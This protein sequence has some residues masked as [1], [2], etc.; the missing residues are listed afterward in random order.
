LGRSRIALLDIDFH[1]NL[2]MNSEDQPRRLKVGTFQPYYAN[3]ENEH[4]CCLRIVRR[5]GQW[6]GQWPRANSTAGM[7][8]LELL[9]QW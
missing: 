6:L 2:E 9:C 7:E 4:S 1:K 8:Q 3:V 5:S